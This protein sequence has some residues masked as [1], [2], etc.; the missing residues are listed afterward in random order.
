M[1]H[2]TTDKAAELLTTSTMIVLPTVE[3]ASEVVSIAAHQGGSYTDYAKAVL[4]LIASRV[5]HWDRVEPGSLIKKGTHERH[6]RHV[7]RVHA[8]RTYYSYEYIAMSDINTGHR[9]EDRWYIDP[10]TVPA[11]PEDPAVAVVMEWY[12]STTADHDGITELLARIDAV[13]EAKS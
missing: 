4:D 10:A 1:N 11:E 9:P 2:T 8:T 13:R 7:R 3:E 5:R 6:V 12:R